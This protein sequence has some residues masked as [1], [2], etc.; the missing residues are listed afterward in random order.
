MARLFGRTK[1]SRRQEA[2]EQ[3]LGTLANVRGRFS[4]TTS[5]RSEGGASGKAVGMGIV[6]LVVL[7]IIFLSVW[8][9]RR[10]VGE[11]TAPVTPVPEEGVEEAALLEDEEVVVPP[12]APS[13]EDVAPREDI[14]PLDEERPG[15]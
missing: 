4:T 12:G 5:A 1:K 15:V 13:A 6:A 8:L 11:E 3:A 7:L 9:L 2:L 10:R 14:P